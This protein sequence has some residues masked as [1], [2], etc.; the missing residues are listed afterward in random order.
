M[1]LSIVTEIIERQ[2]PE[3]LVTETKRLATETEQPTTETEQP[4]RLA[5]NGARAGE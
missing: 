2:Q 1:A 4:E 5:G 3:R